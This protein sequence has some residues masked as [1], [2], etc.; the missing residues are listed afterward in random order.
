MRGRTALGT[1]GSSTSAAL[2][3]LFALFLVF[4]NGFFVAAEFAIV[5]VRPTRIQQLVEEGVKSARTAQM[6]INNLDE[7]L[8]ATQ[9][10]ITL[11]SLGLG[12]VGEP[13]IAELL[14]PPLAFIG[15]W[16]PFFN[17]PAIL[18]V[19]AVVIGFAV[20]TVLHIV[21]G[22][23]MPK[24]M[25]IVSAEKITLWVAGP[26]RAFYGILRWP[27]RGLNLLA[28][29][30]LRR[31]GFEPSSQH[32]TA[33]T[34][35][36]L[37]MLLSASHNGGHLAESERDMID[38]VFEFSERIARELMVPRNEMICLFV[39][40]PISE[41]IA[42]AMEAGH[43]RFPLCDGDKDIVLGM[44]HL[45]D[46]FRDYGQLS[47][48]R[49]IMRPIMM[50]PETISVSRLLGEFQR[51][52]SQLTILVDEYGGTAGLITL[53]DLLEEIVGEIQDEFDEEEPEVKSVG[54]NTFEVDGSMLLQEAED[55]LGLTLEELE[56][57]DTIGGYI[58]SML[59]SKP[60]LGQELL[61]GTHVIQVIEVDGFRITK[62]LITPRRLEGATTDS[63]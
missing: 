9:F 29:G 24:S 42:T 45:R 36:E 7:H 50:V 38:N 26:L 27:I 5:K 18:H 62:V 11:A 19:A 33:H 55:E 20:I 54:H 44:I 63:D 60:E 57:V 31:I 3:L 53:E 61:V 8:S 58:L 28:A 12:W 13:A 39:E 46:I 49:A 51:K 22:E 2:K 17:N 37:R 43:T 52:R 56:G 4:L 30:M 40:D 16:I 14:G 47:D 6:V 15:R 21:F 32:E 34:D 59:A 41:S 1:D 48:L 10:G 23:L 35:E 25:G